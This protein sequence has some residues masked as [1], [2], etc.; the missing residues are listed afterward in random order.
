MT[1]P[2]DNRVP[3]MLSDRE[4]TDIDEWRFENRIPTR[5]D[6]L[7]RLCQIGLAVD[8][9]AGKMMS[10]AENIRIIADELAGEVHER[11]K[12]VSVD[13][14]MRRIVSMQKAAL[15]LLFQTEKVL[16][17]HKALKVSGSVEEANMVATH[18]VE[19]EEMERA[20]WHK[21]IELV[22]QG[23]ID[24]V[25]NNA[26]FDIYALDR[27]VSIRIGEDDES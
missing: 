16:E 8:A 10:S 20:K 17:T 2:R 23:V 15:E 14:V 11:N 1:E 19:S 7:R 3:F 22:Q 6:A 27:A 13:W 12:D 24:A 26:I 25:E 4:L 5:A 18:E 21:A 9:E